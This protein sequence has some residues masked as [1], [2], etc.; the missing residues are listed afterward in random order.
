MSL[1][2]T[3]KYKVLYN[4]FLKNVKDYSTFT[5]TS[6]VDL[7]RQKGHGVLEEVFEDVSYEWGNIMDT[8]MDIIGYPKNGLKRLDTRYVELVNSITAET[9]NLQIQLPTTSNVYDREYIKEVL[10]KHAKDSW[11]D[12]RRLVTKFLIELRDS[13]ILMTQS[14][15]RLNLTAGLMGGYLTGSTAD[16]LVNYNLTSGTS[17]QTLRNEVSGTSKTFE[18]FCSNMF[19][20]VKNNYE[21]DIIYDNEYLFFVNE[22]ADVNITNYMTSHT[23]YGYAENLIRYRNNKL[24]ND[25]TKART[26]YK[27]G[28]NKELIEEYKVNIL[29][30]AITLL[31]YDTKQYEIY[32]DEN[33]IPQKLKILNSVQPTTDNLDFTE[34]YS[35]LS[36]VREFFKTSIVGNNNKSYN[37]KVIN[38]IT[39]S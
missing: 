22:L 16:G 29:K 3:V 37:S 39:I 31:D 9:T 33:K 36:L 21:N 2:G 19:G 17:V 23:R 4:T 32:F 6:F 18:K 25:L 28:I 20:S 26:K 14:V 30:F 1:T 8:S 12:I 34:T 27:K 10:L 7:Y 5:N 13:Q 38:N 15:D 24:I 35:E 11:V